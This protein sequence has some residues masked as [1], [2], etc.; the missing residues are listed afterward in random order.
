MTLDTVA[1]N[2]PPA[3]PTTTPLLEALKAEKSAQKDKEAILRNHAHYKDI[4]S[5]VASAASR[6]EESKKKAAAAHTQPPKPAEPGTG[7][8]AAKK[9]AAK[10][11]QQQVSGQS[12]TTTS[13]NTTQASAASSLPA[14]PQPSAPAPKPRRERAT[15]NPSSAAPPPANA[16][17]V[18]PP[19]NSSATGS[20][21][22]ISPP[23]TSRSDVQPPAAA[24]R[25]SRPVVGI[26]S[27]QFEAALSGAVG[28]T[29]RRDREKE[30]DTGAA[31][32][33]SPKSSQAQIAATPLAP[34]ILQRDAP[35]PKILSRPAQPSNDDPSGTPQ[36]DTAG[37]GQRGRGRGRGGRGARGG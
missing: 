22:P 4:A 15:K 11:S 26:A 23:A 6:K 37:R 32:V 29:S 2:Q 12:N 5:N 17:S 20:S 18:P 30:K 1:A 3:Q 35:A 31:P 36:E 25:R 9:A 13:K 8:R 27:R 33:K 7:K 28:R 16:P 21:D 10:A 24:S 14:K 34:T 19:A